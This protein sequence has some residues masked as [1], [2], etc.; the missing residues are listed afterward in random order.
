MLQLNHIFDQSE[1]NLV[2]VKS[3]WW[4][5]PNTFIS[6]VDSCFFG[7]AHIIFSWRNV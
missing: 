7:D 5:L 2:M 3:F 1:Y 4:P 6:H